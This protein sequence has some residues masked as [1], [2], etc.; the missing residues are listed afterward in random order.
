M[1]SRLRKNIQAGLG[2][3]KTHVKVLKAPE[4]TGGGVPNVVNMGAR[5]AIRRLEDAGLTVRFTGNGHVVSQSIAPGGSFV[6]GQVIN[7]SLRN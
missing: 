5:E 2:M 1:T 6:R 3:G 7:L 4:H